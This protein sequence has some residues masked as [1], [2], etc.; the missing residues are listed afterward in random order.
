MRVFR[1]MFVCLG[2]ICRSPLGH[3]V[4]AH[5]VAQAGLQDQIFVESSGTGAWH[6]GEQADA[7][8]RS[9]AASHGVPIDHRA[10]KFA[11]S[12]FEQYDLILAMDSQNRRDILSLCPHPSL[13]AKVK[14][15]RDFD[16]QGPGDVP[17]PWYGGPEGFEMVWDIVERTASHLLQHISQELQS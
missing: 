17:D 9:V 5:H 6:V 10:Q 2:N 7:R 16:P 12:D 4:F 3:G 15:F 14:M 1:V 13:A 11:S 8:M